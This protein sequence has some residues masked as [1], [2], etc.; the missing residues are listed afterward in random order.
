MILSALVVA[1]LASEPGAPRERAFA[2][3]LP[4][5]RETY[6]GS[7]AVPPAPQWVRPLPGPTLNSATHTER[8]RP[9][10]HGGLVYVGSAAGKALYAMD[11]RNGTLVHSFPASAAVESEALVE[12]DR[13]W[14]TDT[15][16]RTWCYGTDGKELWHHDSGAPILTRPTLHDGLIY[17]TNVEDLVVALDAETGALRWRHQHVRDLARRVELA[18]YAAPPV[19]VAADEVIVGFSDGELVGLTAA[20]GDPRWSLTVGEGRY[21][22]LIA[23]PAARGDLVFASGYYQPLVAI[24]RTT[25][26][27][28]WDLDVGAAAASA[29][30]ERGEADPLLLH[31]GTDGV[32]RAI[33]PRT[34]EEVWVWRS[35]DDGGLSAPVVTEAGVVV[36][37]SNG[38]VTLLDATNG[39]RLWRY[40]A[41][42]ILDGVSAPPS[43]AGR[44]LFFV[45]N[46][47]MLHAM[48]SPAGEAVADADRRRPR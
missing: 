25:R 14:F 8:T 12:G 16:G 23:E 4:V 6:E 22:D 35:G 28:L 10:A 32:L 27:V 20:G 34:G 7:F 44:Q 19:V 45:T 31:P 24:D 29:W 9:V 30:L 43:V 36:A 26:R 41:G 15:G 11:R 37:S 46:A 5:M 3:P 48:L 47:G 17:V 33:A 40:E 1:A 2:V 21:P 39:A 42:V 38:T 13:V 18:L